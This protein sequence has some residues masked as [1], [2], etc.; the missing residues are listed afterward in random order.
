M[1][2]QIVFVNGVSKCGCVIKFSDGGGEYSD[3]HEITLCATHYRPESESLVQAF[4]NL[5]KL[6]E[7]YR[8]AYEEARHDGLV[9][10]E[11]ATSLVEQNEE[12]KRKLEVAEK[13]GFVMSGKP[14]EDYPDDFDLRNAANFLDDEGDIQTALWLIELRRRRAGAPLSLAATDVLAER[15]RQITAEGWTAEHDDKYQHS[16]MLWAACCYVLNTIQKYNR[17]PFDWPWDDSWWKP[18]NPRR[19]LVKANA[20]LLAEIERI[21]RAAESI[22]EEDK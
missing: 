15:R 22:G 8:T 2:N 17:V 14:A 20:L 11:A 9:N 6:A 13:N 4:L 18:S 19:D 3:V 21:D 12:L 1:N 7:V 5:Q 16:E 10:W